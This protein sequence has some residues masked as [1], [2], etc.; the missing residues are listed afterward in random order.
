MRVGLALIVVPRYSVELLRGGRRWLDPFVL[1]ITALAWLS[2]EDV[3]LP[4]LRVAL[5]L[6]HHHYPTMVMV[7]RWA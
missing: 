3:N 1:V 7:T 2:M 4:F 5:S 6:V